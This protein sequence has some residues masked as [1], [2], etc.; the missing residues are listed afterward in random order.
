MGAVHAKLK[1]SRT[2][3]LLLICSLVALD[4]ASPDGE[5][6]SA[7]IGFTPPLPPR[8]PGVPPTVTRKK[9][10]I[11]GYPRHM[12][13]FTSESHRL[14]QRLNME[15]IVLVKDKSVRPTTESI[16]WSQFSRCWWLCHE[17]YRLVDYYQEGNHDRKFKVFIND[18]TYPPNRFQ[19]T[20]HQGKLFFGFLPF[21]SN[22]GA[23]F[24]VMHPKSWH[25]FQQ[26]FKTDSITRYI[27]EGL[28][29][30]AGQLGAAASAAIGAKVGAVA[31]S[32]VPGLGTAIGG[33]MGAVGG[34]AVSQLTDDYFGDYLRYIG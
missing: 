3:I 30:A 27:H 17:T 14:L 9:R 21:S 33:V 8:S 10:G 1:M 24:F 23:V 5:T 26:Q 11:F 34:H 13:V 15:N 20:G 7:Q 25:P 29:A 28:S 2:G 12:D 19:T 31:G 4:Q 6:G 22:D 32:V 16:E 18:A